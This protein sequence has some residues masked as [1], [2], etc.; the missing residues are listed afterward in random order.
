MRS[1]RIMSLLLCT[2]LLSACVDN[3]DGS[4]PVFENTAVRL[5]MAGRSILTYDPLVHQISYSPSRCEFRVHTDNMSDYFTAVLSE[6]PDE[7]GQIVYADLEWTT[8]TDVETKN[9]IAFKTVGFEGDK[10]WLWNGN[11]RIAL[12]VRVLE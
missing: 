12:V 5:E 4:A 6:V 11:G 10:L 2:A 7:I 9:N 1:V 8:Q 3:F